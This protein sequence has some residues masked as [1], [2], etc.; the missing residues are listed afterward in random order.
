MSKAHKKAPV[1]T[2]ASSAGGTVGNHFKYKIKAKNHPT[3]F[4]ATGLPAG[5]S[6][7]SSSGVISGKPATSGTFSIQ[8][9]ATN[10]AGTGRA[11]LT[12][13]PRRA[14]RRSA[15]AARGRTPPAHP[16]RSTAGRAVASAAS[17]RDTGQIKAAP[18]MTTI[19]TIEVTDARMAPASPA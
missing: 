2:S 19:T 18:A 12:V 13:S 10:A 7:D 17:A 9:S 3:S 8:I 16:S 4:G 1:I 6:L 15:P 5:L 14:P 11:T